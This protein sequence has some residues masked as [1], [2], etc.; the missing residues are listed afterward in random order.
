M[1]TGPDPKPEPGSPINDR[2]RATY[3]PCR[4]I[5][6]RQKAIACAVDLAATMENQFTADKRVV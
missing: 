4:S 1:N 2:G 3:R 6:M 5:E